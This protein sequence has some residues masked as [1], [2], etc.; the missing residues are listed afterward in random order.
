MSDYDETFTGDIMH[1]QER[2]FFEQAWSVHICTVEKVIMS[3]LKWPNG[4]DS[5]SDTRFDFKRL[6]PDFLQFGPLFGL[7]P[8]ELRVE[9]QYIG[10]NVNLYYNN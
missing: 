1:C 7:F 4:Y 10:L 9:F 2:I 8:I 6:R 3:G 5:K